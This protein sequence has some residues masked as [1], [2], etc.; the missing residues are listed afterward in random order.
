MEVT[1]GVTLTREAASDGD[2]EAHFPIGLT[3]T[4]VM[5]LVSAGGVC[6]DDLLFVHALDPKV[7]NWVIQ[8][9]T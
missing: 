2:G 8:P 1:D 9:V 6:P 7:Q 4:G 3:A 5:I